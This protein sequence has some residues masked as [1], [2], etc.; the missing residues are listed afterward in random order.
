MDCEKRL[1]QASRAFGALQKAVFMDRDL[2]METKCSVCQVCVLY[3]LLYGSECWTLLNNHQWKLDSFRHRCIRTILGISNL[4]QWS[5]Y[6]TAF[7]IRRRWGGLETATDKVA[8]RR[9]EWL[10]HLAPI[11]N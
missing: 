10:G 4:Q 11:P 3:V 6:I 9:M 5:R 7:E 1:S 2:K 8:K